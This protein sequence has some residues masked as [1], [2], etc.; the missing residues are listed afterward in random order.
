MIN[1]RMLGLA[2]ALLLLL[3]VAAWANPNDDPTSTVVE[4]G[5]EGLLQVTDVALADLGA[6]RVVDPNSTSTHERLVE[7]HTVF[8]V[9]DI[10]TR[11]VDD[12]GNFTVD[13][14]V[15]C[16]AHAEGPTRGLTLPFVGKVY[17]P[18]RVDS[19]E[20]DCLEQHRVVVIPSP[21]GSTSSY[22][23]L[24]PTGVV[25]RYQSPSGDVGYED[26][27][28]FFE[29][30]SDAQGEHEAQRYAWAVPVQ[31]TWT[32][33]DGHAKNVMAPLPAARLLE[34]GVHDFQ[35]V[36]ERQVSFA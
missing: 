10:K 19:V 35:L 22:T 36:D 14:L 29:R 13:G 25:S 18:T 12:V 34:M 23:P 31:S 15:S 3:P 26:E 1:F 5:A 17:Y 20:I 33:A 27:Y 21:V 32:K 7:G 11:V 6:S 28:A 9:I 24:S 16:H 30:W 8:A 2:S 4:G